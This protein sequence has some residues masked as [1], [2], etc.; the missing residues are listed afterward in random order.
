MIR[1]VLNAI[2][3]AKKALQDS[4]FFRYIA[5]A[6]LVVLFCAPAHSADVDIW[7]GSLE[8]DEAAKFMLAQ[9]SVTVSWGEK[10]LTADTVHFWVGEE[11]LT[12]RGNV[13]LQESTSVIVGDQ[14]DF[15]YGTNTGEVTR[16]SARFDEWY[17]HSPSLRR[18]SKDTFNTGSVQ[19]TH[20]N[21]PKPHYVVR[22]RRARISI[23]KRMTVYHPVF[24]VR[25]FPVFY[26]PVW[27][28]SL[29]PTKL[30]ID[31]EAGYSNEAGVIVH[32]RLGYPLSDTTNLRAYIDYYSR[33]GLGKGLEYNYDTP[34]K[35]KGT[36]YGYH[37]AEDYNQKSID[38]AGNTIELPVQNEYWMLKTA[39]WQRLNPLW[40]SRAEVNYINNTTLRTT[41][42]QDNWKT[43]SRDITSNVSFT[44][45][46]KRSTLNIYV[47]RKDTYGINKGTWTLDTGGFSLESLTLPGV[48]YSLSSMFPKLPFTNTLTLAANNTYNRAEDIYIK[49]ANYDA[50]IE[51]GFPFFRKRM[52]LTPSAGIMQQW[53]DYEVILTTT[54]RQKESNVVTRYYTA[55]NLRLRVTRDD[56]W[57]F[58]YRYKIRSRM[59][60]WYIDDEKSED[61][62]E[63]ENRLYY[64][65]VLSLGK[66]TINNSLSYNFGVTRTEVE[67]ALISDWRQKLS[68][69]DN[70][71][72]WLPRRM[73]N[74]VLNEQSR[75][76]PEHEVSYAQALISA[77]DFDNNNVS[78]GMSY[79]AATPFDIGYN[80][81]FGCWLT[82]KWKL[83][84]RIVTTALNQ[85][86]ELRVNDQEIK[87]Y[88]DMHC[89]ESSF[90]FRERLSAGIPEKEMFFMIKMKSPGKTKAK[91]NDIRGQREFYPWR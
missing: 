50:R 62:G 17:L 8:Y 49:N 58:T 7:A 77:G 55:W 48:T 36:I 80:F 81:S 25:W 43:T 33:K 24:W 61:Y 85:G 84:Y 88:R 70:Q 11:R 71:L 3:Q 20:C 72:V 66:M 2:L 67:Q 15:N 59:N 32:T 28:Q 39:H 79:N 89:W 83:N 40:T 65:N 29:K 23:G 57:D 26:F 1:I 21:A 37:L 69:I 53:S 18:T 86:E 9:G 68:P 45:L 38:A 44:R 6:L 14:I 27:T 51:K 47:D 63:E 60:G 34:D 82:K 75:V 31:V 13:M 78:L 56:T 16:A 74:V 10:I 12:A 30:K 64:R 5:V 35:V 73:V 22:A 91:A 87:I 4:V 41:Y 46:G 52:T 42:F 90:T 19:M 54:V 76:Y